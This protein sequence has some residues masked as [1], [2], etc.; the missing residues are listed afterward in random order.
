MLSQPGCPR[1]T[2][3]RTTKTYV[4]T[5]LPVGATLTSRQTHRRFQKAIRK[6]VDEE[7]IPEAMVFV[8]A[9]QFVFPHPC[10]LKAREE[11]GKRPSVDLIKKMGYVSARL[12]RKLPY[13]C[14][15]AKTG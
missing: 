6:F 11:D 14:N 5:C 13:A 1:G 7:V 3:A 8:D 2:T 9:L 4:V 10:I 12:P 15:S